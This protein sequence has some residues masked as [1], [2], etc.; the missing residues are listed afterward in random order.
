VLPRIVLLF[1]ACAVRTAAAAPEP[2][3]VPL[4]L[5]EKAGIARRAFPALASVPLPRGRIRTADGLWLADPEKRPA[6]FQAR[7]LERW[8]DGSARWLLLD[9]LADVAAGRTAT[10]TLRAGKP[11]AARGARLRHEEQRGAH[12]LDAGPVR[13]AL[14]A[15]GD[16][17]V[18]ELTLAGATD[19]V[20][21][22]LP[23][24]GF[25]GARPE[26][27]RGREIA[28]ESSGAVRTELVVRGRY[29]QGLGY[30][31]RIAA[32]AGQP[33][34]RLQHTLTNLADPPY[35]L[36]GTLALGVTGGIARAIAGLDGAGRPFQELRHTEASSA[37]LDGEPTGQHADGWARGV[38]RAGVVTLVM[39]AF[40]KEYP[41]AF[42]WTGERLELDLLAGGNEPVRFGTGAA[43]THELWVALEPEDA[44]QAPR[45]LARAL[46]APLVA[47]PSPAWIVAS[48]ALAQ[49]ITPDDPDARDFLHRFAT[50]FSRYQE[51]ARKER[52]DDGPA[53]S[54]AER[55]SER[56]RVGLYGALNWG[57]WQFPGY[58]DRARGCDA[59]GN[60]E[61]DLPQVL[62]LA[63]AATGA[64]TFYTG[65]VPAARHYRDVDIIYHSPGH[66]ERV[67]LNHPHK[68]G[69]FAFEAAEKVD[70]G[71]TWTEGLIS[72]WR[73]TGETRALAAARGIADALA[74]RADRAHNP[75]HFGWPMIALVAVA[76]ATGEARYR[77]AALTYA[78]GARTSFRPTP[79]AGD[80]KMGILADGMAAVHA[81]T[82]DDRL[83][84]WLVDYAD[85][86]LAAPTGFTDPRYALPLGYLAALTGDERYE[87]RARAV[88]RGLRIGEWGKP[89]AAMGRI[90]FRLLGPL[91]LRDGPAGPRRASPRAPQPPS[92]SRATPR[93]RAAD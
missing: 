92:R 58:R 20:A 24:L 29:P 49:A 93:R 22:S 60:L 38:G 69:H 79:A 35:A 31:V 28:V 67:G 7:V 4:A 11:P 73:L 86:L 88:V 16:A 8:P 53:V 15:G 19:G 32:F 14:P 41:K 6:P 56:P 17:P 33:F 1:L 34:V 13:V 44:A 72:Y 85:A 18:V 47:G 57:D 23:L 25:D 48:G 66:P 76:E 26:A 50:A 68:A 45:E 3:A 89:L 80:W 65:L 52:W 59:W 84:R 43:K 37:R 5:E 36:V 2:L 78:L 10:Y 77:E 74:A 42:R 51:R 82:G 54:C 90:G 70:L 87:A 30:E 63:W 64:R 21:V 75:R 83:K 62:A 61:Y 12:V 27:A 55:T 39:P 81:A 9:F 46:D 91:A 40:W 71:H